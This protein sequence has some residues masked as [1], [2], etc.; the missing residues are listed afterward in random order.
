[1]S[2]LTEKSIS[3]LLEYK[4][5]IPSYQRGYRWTER[6][7]EDLLEDINAFTPSQI[8]KTDKKT[9]YCLQPVVIKECDEE[10]KAKNNLKGT[11][12]EV[13]D[14]QQRLT[15]FF[16]I[17][18]YANEMWV[19]K[20]KIS[21]F[22]IQYETRDKSF[23]FLKKQRI[24]ESSDMASI[25]YV[26][27]DFHHI[28]IAYNKIHDWVKNFK[29]KYNKDFDNNDFQSKFRT[30]SKVI[31]YEVPTEKDA[32]EIFTRINMGKIPLTNAE[33][34][35]A[36][37]LNSSNFP[38]SNSDEV[39]LRQLEIA[40]E[41]DR[42][43]YSLQNEELWY[44]I[45]NSNN[46]LP[47]RIEYLFNIIK[48]IDGEKNNT[49][50]Y[51][52]F[53]FFSEKFKLKNKK[54]IDINWQEIKRIFQTI[55]EWFSDRELYHK[56]GYLI[57]TGIDITVLLKEVKSKQKHEFRKILDFQIAD[58]VKCD[59]LKELGYGNNILIRNILLL[60]NIQTILENKNESN[61]FPFN[62]YKKE[63]W[64]IEHI[65]A[66]ATEMPKNK[67]HRVD[68]LNN[69]KEFIEDDKTLISKI[70]NFVNSYDEQIQENP[71]SF[72]ELANLVLD[73]YSKKSNIET[74]IN[75][76]S[77]LVLLDSGTNRSYKNA[78]FPA[79]RKIII[80]KEK[81]GTF[82]PICTKNVFLKYYS[83]DVRQMTFWDKK[84][85]KAYFE[86]IKTT[87]YQR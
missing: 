57:S 86:N 14:G 39:R 20:Q 54:E 64:D 6:Q 5:F 36:L 42:I 7:V 34:I 43:E 53:R 71:E 66:V 81:N 29:K 44:F 2:C 8:E 72:D 69:S 78:V 1:M 41:W 19:G 76:L 16:L 28:S 67:Q 50:Q 52:T 56:I 87:L 37:F 83:S 25:S 47:T 63:S 12:Y 9:W 3:D 58:K 84:D 40:S 80:E 51:S 60:H 74:D 17:I 70:T 85:R 61:R 24:D 75:D 32:I 27:I 59:N 33:L 79:K 13:I 62:R 11:W 48:N 4:F 73:Y 38:N 26:N 55:E 23:E 18:H 15:S 68:W 31:W 77:N 10:T 65:H 35:K 22:Q 30:N 21:E 82:I 49:D 46:E 45:N